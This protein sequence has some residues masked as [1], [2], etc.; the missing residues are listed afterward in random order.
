MKHIYYEHNNRQ[1]KFIGRNSN[2][3]KSE[4]SVWGK[5]AVSG[6]IQCSL[7]VLWV[8]SL[9]IPFP[10]PVT[11]WLNVRSWW[12]SA[13]TPYPILCYWP[14]SLVQLWLFLPSNFVPLEPIFKVPPVT[15]ASGFWV[16][17]LTTPSVKE[18]I[19][20]SRLVLLLLV[21]SCIIC[22]FK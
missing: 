9:Q 13:A 11:S 2:I 21:I 10:T 16:N 19:L 4:C 7:S 15:W 1:N 6:R 14:I 20:K 22:V 8:G 18:P 3:S 12:Y 5:G 17:N